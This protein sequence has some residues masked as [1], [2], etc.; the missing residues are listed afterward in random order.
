MRMKKICCLCVCIV[1]TLY[2]EQCKQ[3]SVWLDD[4]NGYEKVKERDF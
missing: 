4:D 2:R 3:A 1:Y